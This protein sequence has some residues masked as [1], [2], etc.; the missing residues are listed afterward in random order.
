[1]NIYG[2]FD[3][4]MALFLQPFY[5]H[6]HGHAIRIFTDHANQTGSPVNS[7]PEDY[8][9]VHLGTF[10]DTNGTFTNSE[11]PAAPLG[12]ATD[13]VKTSDD[14]RQLDITEHLKR[15]KGA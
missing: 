13:Y 10:D 2:I 7:H 11:R 14:N 4:K 1:M 15:K 12:N 5:A 8:T 6:N 3:L 9:L